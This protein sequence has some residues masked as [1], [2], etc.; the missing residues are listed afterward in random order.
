MAETLKKRKWPLV[1]GIG[2]ALLLIIVLAAP[3]FV[4][5]DHFRPLIQSKLSESLGRTV[6]IGHLDL[7]LLKG[8]VQAEAITIGDDRAFS[9]EPFLRAKSLAV[10]VEVWP[11]LLHRQLHVRSLNVDAPDIRLLRSPVGKWNFESLG[12]QKESSA[13][14]AAEAGEFSVQKLTITNGRV[15]LGRSG[16]GATSSLSDVSM[17]LNNIAPGA[18]I[19]LAIAAKTASGG[20]VKLNGTVGPLNPNAS[21][22][23][24]PVHLK[25]AAQKLPARDVQGILEALGT[26]LPRGSS[27]ESGTITANLSSDGPLDHLVTTGPIAVTRV[28]LSGFDFASNLG[29]IAKLSGLTTS[30]NTEIENMSSHL[31]VAPEGIRAEQISIVIPALGTITGAGAVSPQNRLDF[32]MVAKLNPGISAL[33]ALVTIPGMALGSGDIPFRIQG[34][35][36]NPTFIPEMGGQA[37]NAIDQSLQNALPEKAKG[38]S[39]LVGGF[40]GKKKPPQ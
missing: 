2:V 33:G 11:L 19:P 15:T 24:A 37:G 18:V 5:V 35:T 34:T 13:E 23:R 25:F 31:R 8:T 26:D 17:D 4:D 39:G 22:D 27:L 38:L 1:A 30:S 10:G 21:I 32:H 9:R 3:F 6:E 20:S 16:G 7:S 29:M 36:S 28:K 12:G 40:L 14:P